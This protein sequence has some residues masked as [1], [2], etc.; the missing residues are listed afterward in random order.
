MGRRDAWLLWGAQSAQGEVRFI[1]V[2]EV[3]GEREDQESEG[4]DN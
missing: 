4:E 2:V 3:W 1:S